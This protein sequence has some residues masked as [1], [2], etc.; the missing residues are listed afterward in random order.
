MR[1]LRLFVIDSDLINLSRLILTDRFNLFNNLI[2]A[3]S[4]LILSWLVGQILLII[5]IFDQIL[6]FNLLTYILL[7]SLIVPLT[8]FRQTLLIARF[9]DALLLN[10]LV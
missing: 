2:G 5:E 3:D 6:I 10:V 1:P 8:R 9:D 4:H 7:R